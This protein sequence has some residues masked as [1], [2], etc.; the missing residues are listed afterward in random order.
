MSFQF[1]C[2]H[3]PIHHT[4]FWSS[5]QRGRSPNTFVDTCSTRTSLDQCT[6]CLVCWWDASGR[7]CHQR[8]IQYKNFNVIILCVHRNKHTTGGFKTPS[9]TVV[10]FR[11][12]FN[13]LGWSN[14]S[15]VGMTRI[16]PDSWGIVDEVPA[17]TRDH[18]LPQSIQNISVGHPASYS[19]G[20]RDFSPGNKAVWAWSWPLTSM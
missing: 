8:T 7:T 5:H 11:P 15:V 10:D 14:D 3:L 12:Y 20:T 6:L 1:S 19:M 4:A 2:C 13:F 18:S 17:L 16:W 9:L